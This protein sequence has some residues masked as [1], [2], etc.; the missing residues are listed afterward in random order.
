MFCGL[1][2]MMDGDGA[3]LTKIDELH[4]KLWHACVGPP[5]SMPP[6]KSGDVLTARLY[7]TSV[8][9]VLGWLASCQ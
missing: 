5:T 7:R 2:G 1:A 6:L 3:Q 9:L 8:W 4:Y